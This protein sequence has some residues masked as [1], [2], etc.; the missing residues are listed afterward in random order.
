[1]FEYF[2][3]KIVELNATYVILEIN[4]IGYFINI[5]MTTYSSLKEENEV[6]LYAHQVIKE[7]S[8]Q[9][10][11][12]TTKKE[13]EVFL[14]LISVSG[15]GANTARLFLSSMNPDQVIQAIVN[16]DATRLCTA[17]VCYRELCWKV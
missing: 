11:G 3:G 17:H 2:R 9:L 4:N 12:F 5:S 16:E 6:K 14:K 15:I 10:F 1:M 13:R 8:H 7:D